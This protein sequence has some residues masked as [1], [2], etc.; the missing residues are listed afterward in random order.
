MCAKLIT[1]PNK[2]L[3]HIVS[4]YPFRAV[5]G[6]LLGC[7]QKLSRFYCKISLKFFKVRINLSP[8]CSKGNI[9]HQSSPVFVYR[10]FKKWIST[11]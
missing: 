11:T 4:D 8:Q 6:F 10:G 7:K 5:S 1:L 9:S 2:P 3:G